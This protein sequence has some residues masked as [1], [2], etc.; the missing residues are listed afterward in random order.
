MS[1]FVG[2]AGWGSRERGGLWRMH[3]FNK[4]ELFQLVEPQDSYAALD[5]MLAHAEAVLQRLELPYRVVALC[6]ANL[7]FSS[8]KTLDL[9]VWMTA[10][11][12]YVEVSSVSNCE[13]FQSRRASLKY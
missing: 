9:E 7:P 2:G 10:Q 12:R 5:Q 13:A 6:A 3:Q 8:A 1:V 4:V 11:G